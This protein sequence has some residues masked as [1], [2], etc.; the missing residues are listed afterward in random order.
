MKVGSVLSSEAGSANTIQTRT[1][2]FKCW[3]RLNKYS[4]KC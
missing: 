4:L 3:F 1:K 2:M